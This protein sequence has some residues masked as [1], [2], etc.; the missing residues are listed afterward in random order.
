MYEFCKLDFSLL[1]MTK[2]DKDDIKD[3]LD[4]QHISTILKKS[5]K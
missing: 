5:E 1:R 3:I 4:L 2:Y